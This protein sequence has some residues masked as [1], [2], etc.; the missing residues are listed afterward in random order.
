MRNIVET[1]VLIDKVSKKN[2]ITWKFCQK[3]TLEL[4]E[5]LLELNSAQVLY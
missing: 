4:E 1:P 3:L 2:R 5:T